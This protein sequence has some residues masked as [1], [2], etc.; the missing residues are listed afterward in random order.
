MKKNINNKIHT[1]FRIILLAAIMSS[2]LLQTSQ[3]AYADEGSQHSSLA[4]HSA[5]AV[6]SDSMLPSAIYLSSGIMAGIHAFIIEAN[7]NVGDAGDTVPSD[8]TA[9]DNVA[10]M[11]NDLPELPSAD[12]EIIINEAREAYS[13]LSD[14]QKDLISARAFERLAEAEKAVEEVRQEQL[15]QE[16]DLEREAEIA[17]ISEEKKKLEDELKKA[18]DAKKEAED[19]K[20]KAEEEKRLAESAK[21][22]A[23][24]DKRLAE[25][26]RKRAEDDKKKAD[27]ARKKAEE[28]KKKSDDARKKAEDDK[29]KADDARKK[30]EDA[31]DKAIGERDKARDERDDALSKLKKQKEKARQVETGKKYKVD[32]NTYKVTKK[33]SGKDSGSVT[34]VKAANKEKISLP[35]YVKLKDNKKYNVT[36]VGS[37]A[38]KAD[39]IESVTIGA[40]IKKISAK[41]FSKSS[42][43][44]II[45]KSKKLNKKSVRN[46]LKGSKI[47]TIYVKAGNEKTNKAYIKKYKKIFTKKNA[48]KKVTVK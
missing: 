41:A 23:E 37:G 26:A 21:T 47:K 30:A 6:T 43:S 16:N 48:G 1:A 19:G 8:I 9:A 27:D 31:R 34:F 32:G 39:K 29:K 14:T 33:A 15:N 2:F 28:E 7:E 25:N 10:D 11:I 35:K 20:R 24:N 3:A 13:S 18:Q 38:F 22:K 12:D 44:K 36:T 5:A 46:C 40:N 45:V 17:K 42:A 4:L